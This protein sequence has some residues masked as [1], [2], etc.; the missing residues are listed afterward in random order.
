MEDNKN[1]NGVNN[2]TE[3][4]RKAAP[5]PMKKAKKGET[6]QA[7]LDAAKKAVVEKNTEKAK[8]EKREFYIPRLNRERS[9]YGTEF[10]VKL[11]NE[12]NQKAIAKECAE[13]KGINIVGI[14]DCASPYVIEDIEKFLKGNEAK[15]K[16]FEK[17][18]RGAL[19]QTKEITAAK[20]ADQPQAQTQKEKEVLK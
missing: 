5:P 13:R 12:L 4:V 18:V 1:P 11:R 20:Q 7:V 9:L 2:E 6:S 17:M 16:D 10:E 8:K 14:I 15:S 19:F 3:V